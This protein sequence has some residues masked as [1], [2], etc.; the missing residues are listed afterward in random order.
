MLEYVAMKKFLTK[1]RIIIAVIILALVF[2]GLKL[3]NGGNGKEYIT[4]ARADVVQEIVVTGKVKSN[5]SVDLG[6]DRTGRVVRSYKVLGDSVNQGETI[7]ELDISSELA[8]LAKEKASLA[9]E[10]AKLGGSKESLA[11]SIREGFAGTD[12]AVRNKADQFF[13]QPRT[14]P[15][16][17]I[18]FT[19]GNYVHYFN[20]P[21]DL[22]LELNNERKA[23]E[24]ELVA[25]QKELLLLSEQ[26]AEVYVDKAIARMNKVAEFLDTMA[27]SV[28]AFTSADF[29]YEST[30]AGYKTAIDSARSSVSAARAS[31]ITAKESVS[32]IG[33]AGSVG[34]ARVNQI[35]ASIAGIEALIAKSRIVAPFSGIITLQDAKVGSIAAPGSKLV[36]IISENNISLE[37]DISE[38]NIGKVQVGNKVKIEFDSFP[39]QI[40][41]GA[42]A[43]I[44][45]G[46]TIIDGVVYY[47]TQVYIERGDANLRSGMTANLQIETDRK[48]NV[49]AVPGFAIEKLDGKS[50]VNKIDGENV[51]RTEVQIGAIGS[52]GLN[53]II[54]GIGEGERVQYGG[55]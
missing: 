21:S 43:Y 41:E 52:D 24:Q 27:Y 14:N 1:K 50:Y 7:A 15:S 46:E 3:K 28:N 11:S 22:A 8:N 44:E 16:F 33:N 29:E 45:P 13:K 20:V 36:S 31:V 10:K 40:F 35:L 17:E 51:V 26:N 54:S 30:V 38:V 12:N 53:E 48:A 47:K 42:V 39:G 23:I 18:K 49:V 4:V 37:A 5:D 32:Q 34:E 6:F 9:E 25:W 2:V 55:N 19:D